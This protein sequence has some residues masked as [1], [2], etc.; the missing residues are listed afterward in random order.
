MVC[1]SSVEMCETYFRLLQNIAKLC[2]WP[3]WHGFHE[4]DSKSMNE[5]ECRALSF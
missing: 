5:Y 2:A 1:S 3:G 4:K